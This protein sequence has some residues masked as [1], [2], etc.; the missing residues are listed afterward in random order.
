MST[1]KTN[2]PHGAP[3]NM[4]QQAVGVFNTCSQRN[5]QM[6][7][8]TGSMPQA[9]AA[10]AAAGGKQSKTTMPIVQ[11]QNLTKS[12]GDEIT[13]HLD[14]PIGGYPIMGSDYAEG[15]GIGMSYSED[16]L[17]INQARFPI[18]M[19]NTMTTFRTPYDQRRM[20]RP[21]AQKLMN[22]YMD[23]SILVHLSG[24]RGFLDHKTEWSV[25]LASHKDFGKIMVNRVKA[26]TKN[27]HLVAGGGSVAELKAT[28]G[29]L[30]IATTD[31][32]SMDVLDSVR[33]WSDSIPLPPPPV[34]F[35]NDQAAT[36]SP[37]R[38]FLASPA[39]YSA[40]ATDPAF[41]SFQANA[42]ARARLAKDHPL[43]LAMLACGT[44]F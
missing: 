6:R 15:K 31:T 19:G 28:A 40:F 14:N 37:I 11:A 16:K 38:V 29:E 18:D 39:Q 41:R 25:P 23:Q 30:T 7:H 10:V 3:G 42:H 22:Q 5:T 34:E 17:R 1:S 20:A 43:F 12:K 2:T 8:L 26:P 32:L 13:F 33:Q 24:A 35:D 9:G 27:R 4:I 21:K 36:D 44:A